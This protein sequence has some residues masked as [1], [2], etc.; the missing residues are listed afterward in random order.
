[1]TVKSP[2]QGKCCPVSV[3]GAV[4]CCEKTLVKTTWTHESCNTL[5][6]HETRSSEELL[7]RQTGHLA[8]RFPRGD[9]SKTFPTAVYSNLLQEHPAVGLK[10]NGWLLTVASWHGEQF[11]FPMMNDQTEVDLRQQAGSGLKKPDIALRKSGCA[12]QQKIRSS[13][14][15]AP[16]LE[17]SFTILFNFFPGGQISQWRRLFIVWNCHM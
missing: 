16:F 1:M 10:T 12:S 9:K 3:H 4:A 2:F 11:N 17:N 15:F 5:N 14:T 7:Q 13:H 8:G 6:E